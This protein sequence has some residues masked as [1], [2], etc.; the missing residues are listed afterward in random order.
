MIILRDQPHPNTKSKSNE[1]SHTYLKFQI[2][3]PQSVIIYFL[4]FELLVRRIG[5][6]FSKFSGDLF[7]LSFMGFQLF[8]LQKHIRHVNYRI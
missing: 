2:V 3:V 5:A 1:V 6:M 4:A 8:I 7:Q